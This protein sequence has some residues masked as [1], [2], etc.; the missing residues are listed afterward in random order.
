MVKTKSGDITTMKT[1]KLVLTLSLLILGALTFSSCTS[2]NKVENQNSHNSSSER[3][4]TSATTTNQSNSPDQPESSTSISNKNI[5]V[6]V[7]VH[8]DTRDN[9]LH[10]KSEVWLRGYGSWHL[11]P[12]ISSGSAARNLAPREAGK[13]DKL[14]IYPDGRDGKEITVP[15]TMTT[16]MCPDGCARDSIIIEISDK[17]IEVFGNPVKDVTYKRK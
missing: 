2:N 8:D 5:M 11:Q 6:R 15:F 12:E 3:E 14:S 4:S 9:K 1:S 17:S 7:I 16:E 10:P 13:A